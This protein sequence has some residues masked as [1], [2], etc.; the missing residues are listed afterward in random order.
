[1]NP[2]EKERQTYKAHISK[3]LEDGGNI[4]KFVLI[5]DD[6]LI[7]VFDTNLDAIKQGYKDFGNV[8]FLVK[9]ITLVEPT[10]HF[11]SNLLEV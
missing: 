7:D 9:E 10:A 6:Q 1:M 11:S 2:L 4:G 3:L 8:P 5:K